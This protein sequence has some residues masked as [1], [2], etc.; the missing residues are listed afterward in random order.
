MSTSSLAWSLW[1]VAFSLILLLAFPLLF[2]IFAMLAWVAFLLW[3]VVQLSSPD[4]P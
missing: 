2:V 1:A 3:L 4:S